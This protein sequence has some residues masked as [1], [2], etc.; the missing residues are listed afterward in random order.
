MDDIELDNLD[1]RPEEEQPEDQ[2]E[3]TNVDTDWRNESIYTFDTSNPDFARENL[4][5]MRDAD[6][7][8][9]KRIGK[10]RKKYTDDKKS[11]LSEIGIRIDKRDSPSLF[12][13][14]KITHNEKGKVNGAEFDGVKVIVLK[15]KRL[16]YTV[17]VKKA[18]KV[19]EFKELVK[20]AEERHA[21]TAEGFVEESISDVPVSEEFVLSVI[22]NSIENL[23][24]YIDEKVAEI[25]TRI[26]NSEKDGQTGSS[27]VVLDKEKIREFRGITKT[28]DHNL[29]NGGLG[30]QEK[31]FRDLAKDE[32]NE[33]KSKLYEEMADVCVL[34]AD[35]I[36]LR[37]NIRP[38]SEE[39]QSIVE[40]ETQRND[41]G[42]FK[43][44]KQWAKKNLGGISVVAISVAGI[45]TTIVMGARTVVKR[46]ASATSKFAKSLAKVA[47]KAAPVIGGL[48]NLAAKVLTLGAKG[49]NFLANNLWILVVPIAYALYERIKKNTK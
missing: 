38:E 3:E 18:A 30:V 31:Y 7:E 39:V 43:R 10:T 19:N 9:G 25:E 4:N 1:K 13:R 29:D 22:R 14:L 8:L 47:E 5:A 28:A 40:E 26:K 34:K 6:R 42:K 16:E 41:L 45:I 35:E 23:E 49:I 37:R 44:F 21:K 17:D 24:D 11:L 27:S 12:E 46:G 20:V 2:E 36:R 33:L 48:L 32:P 15:G